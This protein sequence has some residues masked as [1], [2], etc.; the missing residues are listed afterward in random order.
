M[1]SLHAATAVSTLPWA[2]L[3]PWAPP[4][5]PPHIPTHL[6]GSAPWP[7]LQAQVQGDGGLCPRLQQ[8]LLRR[9]G[10]PGGA[11]GRVGVQ[12]CEG[13]RG[14]AGRGWGVGVM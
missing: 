12:A 9:D 10:Q 8:A 3:F 6:C 1:G 5:H 7:S 11:H 13:H 2:S 4:S 14:R